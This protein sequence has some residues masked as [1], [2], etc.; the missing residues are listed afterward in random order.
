MVNGA[1]AM[2][3]EWPIN[4]PG[5]STATEPLTPAVIVSDTS[6]GSTQAAS[7]RGPLYLP[8]FALGIMENI[9]IQ[10]RARSVQALAAILVRS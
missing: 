3:V 1:S 7:D 2:L 4:D 10:V 5:Q 8:F 9:R 6:A